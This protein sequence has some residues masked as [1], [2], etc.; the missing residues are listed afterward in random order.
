M[1]ERYIEVDGKPVRVTDPKQWEEFMNEPDRRRV[2]AT[3][4]KCGDW[5]ST[6]FL[7]LDHNFAGKGP[8]ILYET[9]WFG[10][11]PDDDDD[12]GMASPIGREKGQV[13]TA[14]REAALTAHWA[15]VVE[16]Q[17]ANGE[18]TNGQ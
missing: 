5:V 2:A 14:T 15:M 7:G 4:L 9:M 11:M 1:L 16:A 13:R 6:V 3:Q 17:K 8:P 10:R 18:F 12:L